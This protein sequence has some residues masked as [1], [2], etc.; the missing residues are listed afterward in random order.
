MQLSRYTHGCGKKMS[1][2][3]V[4]GGTGFI[5]H[6]LAKRLKDEGHFVR[7][8]DYA[9]PPPF[10]DLSI[11]DETD[12]TC[13]L[14]AMEN[15]IRAVH[16]MDIVYALAA[17]MGGM[18]FISYNDWE[19]IINNIAINRNTAIAVHNSD[20]K[21]LF[22]SSSACAYPEYLQMDN[23]TTPYLVEEDAWTGKP[24]TAYGI[25]KLMGEEIYHWLGEHASLD[26]K[27][28]RFH[29]IYGP[30]SKWKGGREKAPAALCRKVAIAKLTG[31]RKVEIWGD[32]QQVRS[33]CYIDDCLDMIDT[34]MRSDYNL[35]VNIGSSK[36]VT[37]DGLVNMIA[38]A[39]GV[40]VM[41]VH[42]AGPEGVRKRNADLSKISKLRGHNRETGLQD[43]ILEL[44]EWVENQLKAELKDGERYEMP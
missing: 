34:L 30:G 42:I 38:L 41:K 10:R 6:H 22:F 13:D 4:T 12:F 17:D 1:K 23:D 40:Y 11:A 18:G 29:N 31:N 28:A 21:K 26:V 8:V 39:A 15:A 27:I 19:I 2:V 9:P 20:V 24:D 37:I 36:E 25:E 3:L 32:G 14:R 44:Y 43:G 16:G 7:V 35:P 5:G 33:F